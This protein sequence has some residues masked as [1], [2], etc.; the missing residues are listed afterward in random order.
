MYFTTRKASAVKL[1]ALDGCRPTR[2]AL[3]KY[4]KGER[5]DVAHL[6]RLAVGSG[7]KVK[8]FDPVSGQPLKEVTSLDLNYAATKPLL[9]PVADAALE[10]ETSFRANAGRGAGP[11]GEIITEA[12]EQSRQAIGEF[13]EYDPQ[14][15]VVAFAP[16]TS[17]GMHLLTTLAVRDPQT[18]FVVSPAAHHSTMLPARETGHFTYFKLNPNGSYNLDHMEKMLKYIYVSRHPVICIESSSNVTGYKHPIKEICALAKKYGAM[19]LIDHAQGASSMAINLNELP[20]RVALA[21]SGHKLYA[22]DG[23]GAIVAPRD[24]LTGPAIVPSGGTITGVT[25]KRIMYA[26]PPHNMEPGTPAYIAQASL[27]KAVITLT[28]AGLNEIADAEERL[29]RLL[30]AQIT[31][32]N[33][34]RVLGEPNLDLV[35]RGPIISFTMTDS[36][37]N[38][39]PPGFILKALE[40]FYGIESR[41]GQ[42]CAH[43][44]VYFLQG[45][46]EEQAYEH[47]ARHQAR[48]RA[49][50]AALPGDEKYHAARLSFGFPTNEQHLL[51]VP[52]YLQ[53]VRSL[54]SDG[55]ALRLDA[56]RGEFFIPGQPRSLTQGTFSLGQSTPYKI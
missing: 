19:V 34:L 49:G 33:G 21:I 29:T 12:L 22:R 28:Q 3:G 43:P 14:N 35:P 38:H 40:A 46:S 39:I 44:L 10:L 4:F 15:H 56:E 11:K 17:T 18:F 2:Q 8:V 7:T 31:Q 41:P 1:F 55:S 42:F 6:G 47:A 26:G 5:L 37:G 20:G 23:S 54:W 9:V 16:N 30:M 53:T 32:V 52:Q 36:E 13:F 48:G 24:F 45:A 27:G 51:M 50:C 25:F